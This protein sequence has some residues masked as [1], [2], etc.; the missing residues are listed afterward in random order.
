M[1][2]DHLKQQPWSLKR[3]LRKRF[4]R[5]PKAFA[6]GCCGLAIGL[7]SALWL[8]ASN[9]AHTQ[10]QRKPTLLELLNEVTTNSPNVLEEP[11]VKTE[12]SP[13]RADDWQS[14]LARQCR[15]LDQETEARLRKL[16]HRLSKEREIVAIDSS[17]Y[18]K[19]YHR[20]PWKKALDPKPRL[21]VLHETSNSLSSAINT[22][23]THHADD[24]AQVSYHTL[25]GR[26]GRVVDAVSPLHRAFGAGYSAFL[27]EWAVTNPSFMGSVNNFALH[28]SLETPEDGYFGGRTHSGYSDAQYDSLAVVLDDWMKTFDIPAEAITTHQHVDLGG[29]RGDPRSFNWSQLQVRLAALKRLC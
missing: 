12:P 20:N 6:L 29:E 11:H 19:R 28:L 18:G 17:N 22:F 10:L 1:V 27:G 21:V 14:P 13:P 2:R 7:S 3:R 4:D 8:T 16:K 25:I 15:N 26:D 9:V 5:H 23:K 24:N